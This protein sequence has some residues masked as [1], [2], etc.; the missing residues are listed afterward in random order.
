MAYDIRCDELARVFLES[1]YP[2]LTDKT[3]DS[4]VPQVAQA[5]QDAAEGAVES[6]VI[7]DSKERR[8]MITRPKA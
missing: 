7:S 3:L 4:L 8:V 1:R 5:I 6:V 2:G